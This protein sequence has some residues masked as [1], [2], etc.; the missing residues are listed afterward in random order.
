MHVPNSLRCILGMILFS[1]GISA[2]RLVSLFVQAQSLTR[3][4]PFRPF[5]EDKNRESI[6]PTTKSAPRYNTANEILSTLWTGKISSWP[7]LEKIT[8]EDLPMVKAALHSMPRIQMGLDLVYLHK[9]LDRCDEASSLS[10]LKIIVCKVKQYY[11][12]GNTLTS[13]LISDCV[14]NLKH[15][16]GSSDVVREYLSL[17]AEKLTLCKIVSPSKTQF[18]PLYGLRRMSCDSPEIRRF[19]SVT[20]D[21]IETNALFHSGFSEL[22][23]ALYGLQSMGNENEVLLLLRAIAE[24][25]DLVVDGFD[26]ER[27]VVFSL[28]ALKNKN[29]DL[30]EVRKL[31]SS[32]AIKMESMVSLIDSHSA[33]L[34]MI[35]FSDLNF[36][37]PIRRLLMILIKRMKM[38]KDVLR[39]DMVYLTKTFFRGSENYSQEIKDVLQIFTDLVLKNSKKY[40]G[41]RLLACIYGLRWISAETLEVSNFLSAIIPII[42]A[43]T[44]QV[45]AKILPGSLCGCQSMSSDSPVL[46]DLLVVMAAKWESLQGPLNEIDITMSLHCMRRFRSNEESVKRIIAVLSNRIQSSTNLT[47]NGQMIVNCFA[48]MQLMSSDHKEV[49][50][51][52]VILTSKLDDCSEDFSTHM[53]SEIIYN[54]QSM[55]SGNPR[56]IKL[57]SVIYEKLMKCKD[58]F[59]AKEI[60]SALYGLRGMSCDSAAVQKLLKTLIQKFNLSRDENLEGDNAKMCF[61]GLRSMS[62]DVHMVRFAVESLA[63]RINMK[64]PYQIGQIAHCLQGLKLMTS[65]VAEVRYLLSILN[66][67]LRSSKGQLTSIQ[68]SKCCHGLQGMN[69]KE[70]EVCE[71]ISILS[72]KFQNSTDMLNSTLACTC[73]FGLQKMNSD[74]IEVRRFLLVLIQ[75]IDISPESK[76]HG[77]GIS[78]CLFGMQNMSSDFSEVRHLL[79]V[80]RTIIDLAPNWTFGTPLSVAEAIF[81]LQ[82]MNCEVE[83]VRDI[84]AI[85]TA[86]L[87]S[88]TFSEPINRHLTDM[89]IVGLTN[90]NSRTLEVRNLL[91]ALT[92]MLNRC[93]WEHVRS[94]SSRLGQKKPKRLK[95]NCVEV[96]K[97]IAAVD[98]NCRNL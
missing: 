23:S 33:N 73:L 46:K 72:D 8:V 64:E 16:D 80:V 86:R 87:E 65:D 68:L 10:I 69:S 5:T 45:Y 26:N 17:M 35:S 76:T 1:S 90:M 15:L 55:N 94:E 95:L 92:M 81:G 63:K 74:K 18:S 14:Y 54:L 40:R 22:C 25:L 24:R 36:T 42:A 85:I 48:G 57:I 50:D 12:D 70:V 97:F 56:V 83:E 71:L 49:E 9:I 3:R 27:N 30:D 77:Y 60:S 52:I 53:L 13:K 88:L 6:L 67:K 34:S 98:I 75:K 47:F 39:W 29:T 61:Y 19:L 21:L 51:L 44:N 11:S 38:N 78:N 20:L 59:C 7:Q 37:V 79:R 89:M 66:L 96:Q 82:N 31:V 84:L 4:F 2:R 62:S 28:A 58:A 32:I 91:G 41:D 43:D 93:S